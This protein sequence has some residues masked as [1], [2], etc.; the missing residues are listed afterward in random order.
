MRLDIRIVQ[1]FLV[2]PH[3]KG[4]ML[5]SQ[6]ASLWM[7]QVRGCCCWVLNDGDS[8]ESTRHPKVPPSQPRLERQRWCLS[9]LDVSETLQAAAQSQQTISSG[10]RDRGA[11]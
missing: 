8:S 7:S 2:T 9:L 10:R 5:R 4:A 11:R 1:L 3:Q 6:H